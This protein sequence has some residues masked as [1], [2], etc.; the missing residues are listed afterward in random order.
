[1]MPFYHGGGAGPVQSKRVEIPVF[2]N[3]FYMIYI[4]IL[5]L[6]CFQVSILSI[7]PPLVVFMAKSP[8][9]KNY[10]MTSIKRVGSGAAPLSAE[11]VEEFTRRVNVDNLPQGKTEFICA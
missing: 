1:M 2:I 7:V 10:D 3:Q 11:V 5:I 6:E 8:L 9:V 4:L